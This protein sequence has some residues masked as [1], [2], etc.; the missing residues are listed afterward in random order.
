[1][2]GYPM[3]APQDTLVVTP[4]N[5]T[6]EGLQ[7]PFTLGPIQLPILSTNS[8]GTPSLDKPEGPSNDKPEEVIDYSIWWFGVTKWSGREQFTL[9]R[10]NP[11]QAKSAE[12]VPQVAENQKVYSGRLSKAEYAEGL[13]N[14]IKNFH[15]GLKPGTAEHR[16]HMHDR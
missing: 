1:M 8:L 7:Q 6:Q 10:D 14:L 12:G 16:Q 9:T 4:T 11:L 15:N 3:K 13:Q 2:K 5:L